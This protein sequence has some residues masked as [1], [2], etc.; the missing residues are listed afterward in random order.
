MLMSWFLLRT[1][2]QTLRRSSTS[3][4]SSSRPPCSQSASLRFS[5]TTAGSSARTD[6][7]LVGCVPVV[8]ACMYISLSCLCILNICFQSASCLLLMMMFHCVFPTISLHPHQRSDLTS[9]F[10]PVSDG[11][12]SHYVCTV[13]HF[14]SVLRRMD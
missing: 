4:S 7:L 12:V 5:P 1:A 6:P 11:V 13:A 2:Y 14:V 9:L 3:S 10:G 8:H